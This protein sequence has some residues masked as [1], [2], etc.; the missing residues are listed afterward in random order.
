M[1]LAATN[2]WLLVIAGVALVVIVSAT[3]IDVAAKQITGRPIRGTYDVVGMA[4]VFVIFLGLPEIFR[5][6][7]NIAVDLI[8]EMISGTWSRFLT[9]FAAASNAVYLAI[10]GVASL[11]V[12]WD[13]FRFDTYMLDTG[14]PIWVIWIPIVYGILMS[15][16]CAIG[17]LARRPVDD[18]KDVPEL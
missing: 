15:L 14:I 9:V 5:T 3:L 1:K 6:G 16:I 4:L 13:A 11:P 8:D 12:A 2:K 18:N 17:Q 10:I 7:A